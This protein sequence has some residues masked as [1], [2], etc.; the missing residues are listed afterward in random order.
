M[1]LR[2]TVGWFTKRRKSVPF[3]RRDNSG[4]VGLHRI[5]HF[6]VRCRVAITLCARLLIP[7]SESR[8]KASSASLTRSSRCLGLPSH[9]VCSTCARTLVSSSPTISD[10]VGTLIIPILVGNPG[11]LGR[12]TKNALVKGIDIIFNSTGAHLLECCETHDG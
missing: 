8:L 6:P 2:A 1:S 7:A 9:T 4:H 11:K 5:F 3:C 12:L 10:V